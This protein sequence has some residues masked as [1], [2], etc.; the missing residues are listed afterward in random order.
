LDYFLA[1]L[2]DGCDPKETVKRIAGAMLA[3]TKENF[4]TL[5]E[6]KFDRGQFV[7]FLRMVADE[8][9]IS[10]QYKMIMEQ[11]IATGSS[12]ESLVKEL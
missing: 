7:S 10:N 4:L 6:L 1:C 9:L 11:M 3:Y 2:D 12:P 5:S 8:K